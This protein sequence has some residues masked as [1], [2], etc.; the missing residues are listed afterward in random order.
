MCTVVFVPTATPKPHEY[1]PNE[2]R[3]TKSTMNDNSKSATAAAPAAAANQ[4]PNTGI[5][6]L[7]ALLENQHKVN[8]ALQAKLE[9]LE[10][11]ER[12]SK[13]R[14]MQGR[15]KDTTGLKSNCNNLNYEKP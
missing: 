5:T 10:A 12:E 4:Q 6:R 8:T 13:S 2:D 15:K 9:S 3:S 11:R 1:K 14:S 7:K